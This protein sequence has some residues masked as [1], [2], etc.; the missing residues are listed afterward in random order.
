MTRFLFILI[1]FLF[2][3]FSQDKYKY[4]YDNGKPTTTGI[5]QYV[6]DNEEKFITEYSLFVHD[7]IYDAYFTTDKL[8]EYYDSDS[9]ELGCFY[10]PN[11][12]IITNEPLFI[13]Y[14]LN[15]LNK[16]NK[17]CLA[18]SNRFVKGTA[19]HEMT[20]VYFNQ[21]MREMQDEKMKVNARYRNNINIYPN[22]T[23]GAEFIEEGVC[24]YVSELMGEIIPYRYSY[25]PK[26]ANDIIT[27]RNRYEIKYRYS[28]I[29]VKG[30]LSQYSDSLKTG[31]KILLRN[32]PP[33]T[34]E[35]LLPELY[36]QR[37]K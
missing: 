11:D 1:S 20:H 8:S 30:F 29:Y 10:I 15:R 21:I 14:E 34:E 7:T 22:N 23:Y 25:K 9:N 2:L 36:Y 3:S 28:R 27:N 4:P 33:T 18:E 32:E 12:I 5:R 19:M 17:K 35:M 16:Y 6:K 26:N 24:E 13:D 31:I 37:L